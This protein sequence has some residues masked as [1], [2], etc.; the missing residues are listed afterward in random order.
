MGELFVIAFVLGMLVLAV[1]GLVGLANPGWVGL[2][3]R[4]QSSLVYFGSAIFCFFFAVTLIPDSSKELHSAESLAQESSNDGEVADDTENV[5]YVALRKLISNFSDLTE[6]Q[7]GRWREGNDWGHWVYGV[8]VISEVSNTSWVSEISDAAFEVTC[9]LPDGNRAI[10][11]YDDA[12]EEKVMG[13]SRG[14]VLD[15]RGRLKTIRYWGFWSSGYV[16]VD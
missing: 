13:F 6:A 12:R 9:E 4:L 16:Q 11:F 5:E 3:G 1:L 10:L 14:D 2:K 8:C 7:R 15:F